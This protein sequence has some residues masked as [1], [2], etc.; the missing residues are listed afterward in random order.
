MEFL[1]DICTGDAR[2]LE[3]FLFPD[4]L[5][6]RNK[7]IK[8]ANTDVSL[9]TLIVFTNAQRHTPSPPPHPP[10]SV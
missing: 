8:L 3:Q 6:E 10:T 4:L 7:E 2:L 1:I 5:N 9:V